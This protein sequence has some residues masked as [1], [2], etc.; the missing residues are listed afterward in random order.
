MP[1]GEFHLQG[2][3]SQDA[4]NTSVDNLEVADKFMQLDKT[5]V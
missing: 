3:F 5:E 4:K 2:C 1:S